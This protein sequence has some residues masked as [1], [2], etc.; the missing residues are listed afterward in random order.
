MLL[1]RIIASDLHYNS[2]RSKLAFDVRQ[3]WTEFYLEAPRIGVKKLRLVLQMA[4]TRY[5]C[6]D[7][8]QITKTGITIAWRQLSI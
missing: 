4:S 3:R 6:L 7:D 1:L 2:L 8:L 5:L